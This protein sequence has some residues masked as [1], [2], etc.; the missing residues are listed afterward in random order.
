M[1]TI[2]NL[3]ILIDLALEEDIRKPGDVT[4]ESIF[5]KEK[6]VFSLIA[7]D[8]GTLCGIDVFKKV[9]HKLDSRT[10]IMNNFKDGDVIKFGD[11]VA[12]VS[13]RVTSI[14][15]AERTAL[16]F[17]SMLSAVAT[18]TAEYVKEAR[19]RLVV[20]DTRK[21][22]PGFRHL[23]KYA[24]RC[25][26]GQNHRMGLYDMVMIKDN[27]ID[28]AGGIGAAVAKVR[29]HWGKRFK[30]EVETRNIMEVKEALACD[31]DRIMLD[32][33]CDHDIAEAVRLVGNSCET[34]ASGNITLGRIES[35][36][37]TG[38]DCISSGELTSS[39]RAFDFS[40]QEQ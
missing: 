33:M 13:G 35:L 28:A 14:L 30:I 37:L 20:L 2:P 16:N 38:V 6:H 1:E 27:H 4:S 29:D 15:K 22:I 26:G 39:I 23:Q 9:M 11:M 21:T 25:G 32:N 34:E 8:Y 40:L 36:A 17:L 31:V 10:I 18:R 12:E 7:K 24:V 19:G 5:D 3:D